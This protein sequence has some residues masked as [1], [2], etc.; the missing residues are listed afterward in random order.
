MKTMSLRTL[1]ANQSASIVSVQAGGELG[2]RIREMGLIPGV[3]VTLSGRAP[4]QDP[5]AV[6]AM[7]FVLTLRNSEADCIFVKPMEQQQ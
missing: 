2:R 6:T 4:L 1:S 7:G 3:T 5:V